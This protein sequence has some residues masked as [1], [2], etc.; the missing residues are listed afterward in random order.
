MA[1]ET[2]QKGET[3]V[4]LVMFLQGIG[5]L[6]PWNSFISASDYFVK[7]NKIQI[8]SW[9]STKTRR[10]IIISPLLMPTRISWVCSL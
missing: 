10:L 3:T 1:E 5:I 2:N 9:W 4:S 8:F 7:K 6:F